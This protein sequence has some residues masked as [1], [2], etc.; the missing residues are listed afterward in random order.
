MLAFGVLA[1][2]VRGK[3]RSRLN[4]SELLALSIQWEICPLLEVPN[5]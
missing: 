4:V 1:A 3:R 2:F 5:T